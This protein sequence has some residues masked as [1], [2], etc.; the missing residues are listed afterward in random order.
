LVAAWGTRQELKSGELV[1]LPLLRGRI[2]RQ[3]VVAHLKNK[4]V[5]LAEQTFLALCEAVGTDLELN[6]A[7]PAPVLPK[8][9]GRQAK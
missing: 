6:P 1:A 2:K 5:T 8:R 9:N 3:W 4:A 7:P